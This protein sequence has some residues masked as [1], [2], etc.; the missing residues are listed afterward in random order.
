MVDMTQIKW[1]G[2]LSAA[3][4]G[5]VL[6]YAYWY[7]WGCTNGCAIKSI[8]WRMSLW[9]GVMGYLLFDLLYDWYSKRN[10]DNA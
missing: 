3:L 1:K 6:G 8:W 5:A 7:F 4:L 9:G 2:R 10:K